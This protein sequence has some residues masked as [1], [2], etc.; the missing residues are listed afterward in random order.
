MPLSAELRRADLAAVLKTALDAVVVMRRDGTVAAWND[1]AERTFG[2]SAAEAIGERMS[3][4][5][6]PDR[7]RDAHEHGLTRY[8]ETGEGQLLDRHIEIS[9]VHRDGRELPVELSI[10]PTDQFGEL[11]FLGFLRDISER[12]AAQRSQALL[13]A[14][15][16]HRVKNMLAVVAGIA[17]QTAKAS[18]T[19]EAF[20]ESFLGRLG[21]L[22]QAHDILTA[23]SWEATPLDALAA[24]LLGP[25]ADGPDAPLSY[26]GPSVTLSPRQIL[27]LSLVFHELLTN[28]TKYGALAVPGGRIAVSWRI[29]GGS[30]GL[31]WRE[32]GL[33]GVCLPDRGG[34]GLKMIALSAEHELKGK[35][36]V[37]WREDGL[38]LDLL[39]PIGETGRGG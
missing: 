7:Y 10:T 25:Y 12:K 31:T 22:S 34:F 13:L 15:L 24:S 4:L 18:P 11:V 38:N 9:A 35:M 37:D 17:H 8:L 28:A 5:I 3:A 30:L 23:E 20:A 2:W 16:S 6:I 19:V 27:S 36:A 32:S 39:F 1:V 14:E 26:G 33:S 21:S 29:E